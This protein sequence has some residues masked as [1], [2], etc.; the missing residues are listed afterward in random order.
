M[1]GSPSDAAVTQRQAMDR[2]STPLFP[3][4]LCLKAERR[5]VTYLNSRLTDVLL[6]KSSTPLRLPHDTKAA[7]CRR[8]KPGQQRECLDGAEGTG[9]R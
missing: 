3:A 7:F 8:T 2:M 1:D 6:T 4:Y 5:A 9:R